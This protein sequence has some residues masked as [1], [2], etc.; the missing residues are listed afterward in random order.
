MLSNAF[1]RPWTRAWV[2]G[3]LAV[4]VGETIAVRTLGGTWEQPVVLF[5]LVVVAASLCVVSS[6]AVLVRGWRSGAAETAMLGSFF[7]SV[8]LLPLAHGLTVPGILYGPNTAT[9]STVFWAVPV[10]SV[11][12]LPLA[13]P[14]SRVANAVVSRWRPWVSCHVVLLVVLFAVSLAAPNLFPVPAMGSIPAAVGVAFSLAVCLALSFRHLRFAWIARSA[15]PLA[16]SVGA[17]LVGASTIVFLGTAPWTTGFW[18]AHALDITGVSVATIFAVNV[19]RRS[20]SIESL[21][22]PVEAT[23][24]LRAIELGLDPIVR[25]F[26]AALDQK[27]PITRDHVV[28]T[29]HMAS[30]VAIELDVDFAELSTITLGALLHDVGKLDVPDH[31]LNKA[32]RLDD[33]EYAIIKRHTVDGERLIAESP[34]LA[35]LAPIIRGHHERIDG[36]GYPD[37]LVGESIPL[38]ARIVAACD[39]YDAMA[40]TRKYR[41]GFGSDR[42]LAVLREH[43][44]S[45]WDPCVVTAVAEVVRRRGPD[46]DGDAL[47]AVGRETGSEDHAEWCGCS[48]ALPQT[49][50]AAS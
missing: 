33:D 28:R 15:G 49:L 20:G 14:R 19:Y 23:T 2:A 5:W 44:G 9:M 40:N 4:V 27:D 18:L 41:T 16:V 34:A 17:A 37:Q 3:W 32:G 42:A 45:Q 8:S 1:A 30:L 25:R 6:G 39:A 48:D 46:F 36:D 21:L 24:P 50:V 31:V 7:M 43:A 47:A 35:E 13:A 22:A 38:G 29:A 10:G 11:V 26:V 12:L